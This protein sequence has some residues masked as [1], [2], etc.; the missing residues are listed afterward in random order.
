[1]PR[2]SRVGAPVA[3]LLA[4]L[5]LL[6]AGP[7][8]VPVTAAGTSATPTAADAAGESV[9][10][11]DDVEVVTVAALAPLGVTDTL[12]R[13]DRILESV[14]DLVRTINQLFGEG[15]G[16]EGGEGGAGGESGMEG[17]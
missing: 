8:A 6:A 16:M 4:A 9:T 15:E 1:M 5:V 2:D 17:G 11:S 13:I 14:L 10:P 7:A 12:Q 3:G